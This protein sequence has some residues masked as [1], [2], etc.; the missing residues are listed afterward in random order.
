[1]GERERERE[2]NGKEQRAPSGLRER[3]RERERESDEVCSFFCEDE[4]RVVAVPN[5]CARQPLEQHRSRKYERQESEGDVQASTPREVWTGGCLGRWRQG[6]RILVRIKGKET[7]VAGRGY[8]AS[9]RGLAPRHVHTV[10]VCR[11]QYRRHNMDA[12][13]QLCCGCAFVWKRFS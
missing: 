2:R 7:R 3:E 11:L 6:L 1:M 9:N 13:K 5:R 4:R 12:R 8:V 10:Q